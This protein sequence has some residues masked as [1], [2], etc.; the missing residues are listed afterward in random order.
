MPWNNY[1]GLRIYG[2][3]VKCENIIALNNLFNVFN[4]NSVE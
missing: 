4:F 3:T 2:K 1:Q